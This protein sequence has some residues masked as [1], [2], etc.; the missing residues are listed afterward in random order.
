MFPVSGYVH[1]EDHLQNVDVQEG[2][3]AKFICKIKT[4]PLDENRLRVQWKH[5]GEFLDVGQAGVETSSNQ[6]IYKAERNRHALIVKSARLKD[7][8]VYTCIASVGLDTDMSSAHL[9]VKGKKRSWRRGLGLWRES[10]QCNI[11]ILHNCT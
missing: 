6:Y 8:G 9:L 2:E 1:I 11:Y 4:H 5:N 10:I 3:R 7:T